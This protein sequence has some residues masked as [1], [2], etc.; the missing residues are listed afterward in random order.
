M[1]SHSR[2]VIRGAQKLIR[3]SSSFSEAAKQCTMH[4]SRVVSYGMFTRKKY[5]W[6]SG[7]HAC[8]WGGVGNWWRH[9][10]IV[11]AWRARRDI[12]IRTTWPFIR[13]PTRHYCFSGLERKFI[14]IQLFTLANT[15]AT[16]RHSHLRYISTAKYSFKYSHTTS[17]NDFVCHGF[18]FIRCLT[19]N[20][21]DQDWSL[22]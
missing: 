18:Q 6:L 9:E 15:H 19:S 16:Q 21:S 12:G 17:N 8:S 10:I 20:Q 2:R 3:N 14:S 1:H 22:V 5:P 4:C 13:F 7:S 11:V